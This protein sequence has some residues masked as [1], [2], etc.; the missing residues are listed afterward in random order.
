MLNCQGCFVEDH[1]HNQKEGFMPE[2]PV[3]EHKISKVMEIANQ[4]NFTVTGGGQNYTGSSPDMPG[5]VLI[6]RPSAPRD[7]GNIHMTI[8]F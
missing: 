1:N 3:P 5:A 6:I 8:E 7:K 4:L 2:V